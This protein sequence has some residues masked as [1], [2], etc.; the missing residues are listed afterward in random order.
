MTTSPRKGFEGLADQLL[1]VERPVHTSA[2]V[3]EGDAA[4]HRGPDQGDH[5]RS[6]R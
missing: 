1:V 3:E 6:V 5:L 4:F 2:G